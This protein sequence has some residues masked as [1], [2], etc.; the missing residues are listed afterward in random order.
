MFS[1]TVVLQVG[2]VGKS[3]TM[4]MPLPRMPPPPS[5]H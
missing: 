5:G 4:L 1:R 2:V 3:D